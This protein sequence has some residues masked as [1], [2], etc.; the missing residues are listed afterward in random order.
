[1]AFPTAFLSK[2]RLQTSPLNR[3]ALRRKAIR[4]PVSMQ[5]QIDRHAYLPSP[6][7]IYVEQS[8]VPLNS[9][10]VADR[11]PIVADR[12]P[13]DPLILW[14]GKDYNGLFAKGSLYGF[15]CR[16][17]DELDISVIH[18]AKCIVVCC[19]DT[20]EKLFSFINFACEYGIPSI[21]VN[22]SLP[23]DVSYWGFNRHFHVDD[24][25][26]FWRDLCQ[27]IK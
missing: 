23:P 11:A 2:S 24:S 21:W 16:W 15:D 7:T 10:T 20:V 27:L 9:S 6:H 22:R 4:V 5:Q 17:F 1:M 8:V 3:R 25:A 13:T 14:M 26:F 19:A 18:Y 12:A